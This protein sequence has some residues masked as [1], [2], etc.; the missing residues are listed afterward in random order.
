MTSKVSYQHFLL[1]SCG[2]T[3]CN[4]AARLPLKE[5]A[6]E[7]DPE[8]TEVTDLGEDVLK[9]IK[10]QS[11]SNQE[12]LEHS[13]YKIVMV[14]GEGAY[15][16]VYLAIDVKT[17]KKYAVKFFQEN[18]EYRQEKTLMFTIQDMVKDYDR[19]FMTIHKFD[20]ARLIIF[21][22]IGICSL[23]ELNKIFAEYNINWFEMQPVFRRIM[24]EISN[25]F[26]QLLEAGIYH[27]DLK[28]ANVVF[29]Q[30]FGKLSY[31]TKLIDFGCCSIDFRVFYGTR[32]R[33]IRLPLPPSCAG[34]SASAPL[35]L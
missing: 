24:A 5:S 32:C 29:Y 27:S 20:D 7:D 35:C 31:H 28:P 15:G 10:K 17:L 18:E 4:Q 30:R 3:K 26:I 16:C 8:D 11:L 2:P 13:G 19:I 34:G 23:D 12:Q 22:E 1:S 21:Y 6:E 9:E 25:I 33:R 14:L